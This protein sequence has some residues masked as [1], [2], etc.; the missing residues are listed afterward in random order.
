MLVI[1]LFAGGLAA[2]PSSAQ[3]V[4]TRAGVDQNVAAA[5]ASHLPFDCDIDYY[6]NYVCVTP[7]REFTGGFYR[8]DRVLSGNCRAVGKVRSAWNRTGFAQRFWQNNNCTGDNVLLYV[9]DSNMDFPFAAYGQGG[10]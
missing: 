9:G 1:T 10:I 2:A 5:N 6:R 7:E 8:L 3:G 4:P